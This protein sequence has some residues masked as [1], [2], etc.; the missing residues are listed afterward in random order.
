VMVLPFMNNELRRGGIRGLFTAA[1]AF[2][3][4]YATI[5]QVATRSFIK[6]HRAAVVAFLSDYVVG[7]KWF[8]DPAN[9]ARALDITAEF[10][11]S[12]RDVLDSYFLTGKDYYRDRNACVNA[13]L[14]QGPV[15]AMVEQGLL[16]APLKITD[17]ID[18]SLL[19]AGCAA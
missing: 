13:G 2:G 12:P 16:A 6:E 18:A 11:K 5:F 7:L 15:D 9:R 8:Y 17:Y 3:G 4:P 14:I 10:T 1:D 19:P